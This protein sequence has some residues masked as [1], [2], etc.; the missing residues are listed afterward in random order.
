MYFVSIFVQL[1]ILIVTFITAI[2][3]YLY[4]LETAALRKATVRQTQLGLMPV[5]APIFEYNPHTFKLKNIGA[6]T[7][8][9]IKIEPLIIEQFPENDN[10]YAVKWDFDIIKILE[11]N[12][13]LK[14]EFN[15]SVS[16]DSPFYYTFFPKY[17]CRNYIELKIEFNDIMGGRYFE[18]IKIHPH[19]HDENNPFHIFEHFEFELPI[20]LKTPAFE[21]S[22]KVQLLR[23]ICHFLIDWYE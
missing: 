9:N 23:N 7:A 14:I 18:K 12:Q 10:V 6:N 8:F 21:V 22:N 17:V 5:I 1:G 13:M 3:I 19:A 11:S 4:T 2:I 15:S 20:L 16:Q